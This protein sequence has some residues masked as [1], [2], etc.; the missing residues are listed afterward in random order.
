[1][2]ANAF[3]VAVVL[4]LIVFR[5]DALT[6]PASTVAPKSDFSTR[7]PF[8]SA[9]AAAAISAAVPVSVPTVL[10][11]TVP[12]TFP[13]N[14]VSVVAA[15]DPVSVTVTAKSVSRSICCPALP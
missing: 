3:T 9:V 4:P 14:V 6:A 7:V 12:P 2:A 5:S 10:A 11:L 15:T 13:S 8:V 1:M